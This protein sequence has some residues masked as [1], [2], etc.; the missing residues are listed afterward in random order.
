MEAQIVERFVLAVSLGG[1]S[2]GLFSIETLR[3]NAIDVSKYGHWYR[4]HGQEAKRPKDG[5][6]GLQTNKQTS[7][8]LIANKSINQLRR[9]TSYANG[10][11]NQGPKHKAPDC[12]QTNKY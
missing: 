1:C 11:T 7:I 3:Q 6:L 4:T 10:Q 5:M 8:R 12:K 9:K 2:I